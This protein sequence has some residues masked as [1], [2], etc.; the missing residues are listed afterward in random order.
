MPVNWKKVYAE[1]HHYR[2]P[3][4]WDIN[5]TMVPV[6][7]R[8]ALRRNLDISYEMLR[9]GVGTVVADKH[10]ITP[11]A[12]TYLMQRI[13]SLDDQGEYLLSRA[14]IPGNRVYKPKRRKAISS[15]KNPKGTKCVLG[16]LFIQVEGFEDEMY[17]YVLAEAQG[18]PYAINL[19]P[20]VFAGLAITSLKARK[21]S[22]DLWP[23][24]TTSKGYQTWRRLLRSL[25]DRVAQEKAERSQAIEGLDRLDR[26][27]MP[28]DEIQ[29]DWQ[30]TDK[31][32]RMT[33]ECEGHVV[34]T[35]LDR[36]C[37]LVAFCVKS[38]CVVAWHLVLSRHP[39]HEDILQVIDNIYTQRKLTI[40]YTPELEHHPKANY[41]SSVVPFMHMIGLN[42]ISMDNA[43]ANHARMVTDK[44]SGSG[45]FL[46]FGHGNSPLDRNFVESIFHYINKG[47]S[48]LSASTTGSHPV[49]PIRETAKNS[50][51]PPVISIQ[52][53]KEMLDV[54]ISQFNAQANDHNQGESPLQRIERY[55]QTQPL[56][57]SHDFRHTQRDFFIVKRPAT[58]YVPKGEPRRPEIKHNKLVYRSKKFNDRQLRGKSV[59]IKYDKRDI[60]TIEVLTD[61]GLSLGTLYAQSAY[62]HYPL[63]DRTHRRIR[64][65][66]TKHGSLG[67]NPL[68]AYLRYLFLNK[69]KPSVAL[70]FLRVSEE[71][72]GSQ[73]I[74]VG[75]E[76]S[77]PPI[78]CDEEGEEL[79]QDTVIPLKELMKKQNFGVNYDQE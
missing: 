68:L 31:F 5:E 11:A 20:S 21:W 15:K 22:R 52:S 41:P 32:C 59:Q 51:K 75:D 14:V 70:E 79:L 47:V 2:K 56:R 9:G 67:P 74:Y 1:N 58:V 57:L 4:Y 77:E 19:T 42:M 35:R 44:A 66:V 61:D 69:G 29:I 76:E 36:C 30:V 43:W 46:R 12:V 8:P 64:A 60:R 49:D 13:F 18:Q 39:T 27:Q 26:A 17:Q 54:W 63:S 25:R 6:K 3:Q 71:V 55:V 72:K 16:A 78:T 45:A 28:F 33:T 7:N 62:L 24:C 48:H 73:A 40:R 34:D 38:R 37:L 53:F 65:H 23:F 50:K 10:Y